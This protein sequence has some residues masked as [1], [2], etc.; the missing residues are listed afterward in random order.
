MYEVTF[1]KRWRWIESGLLWLVVDRLVGRID[2]SKMDS[3]APAY[4]N[5][6]PKSKLELRTTRTRMMR[7]ECI[8]HYKLGGITS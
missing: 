6:S 8:A 1:A 7:R 4:T 2:E 3:S 5:H